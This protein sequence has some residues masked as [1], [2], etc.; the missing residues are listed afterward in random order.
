MIMG[1]K[2][3]GDQNLFDFETKL[4]MINLIYSYEEEGLL[5]YYNVYCED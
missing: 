4:E 3:G 1:L 5:V 2:G